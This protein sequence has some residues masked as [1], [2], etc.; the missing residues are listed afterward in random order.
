MIEVKRGV[1]G[2]FEWYVRVQDRVVGTGTAPSDE[3]AWDA[4]QDCVD[5]YVRDMQSPSV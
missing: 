4:A 2:G 5:E 3:M 1:F